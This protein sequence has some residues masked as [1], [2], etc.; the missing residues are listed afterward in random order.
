MCCV[1]KPCS[2]HTLIFKSITM[3]TQSLST[4]Q[5]IHLIEVGE[6]VKFTQ[7]YKIVFKKVSRVYQLLYLLSLFETSMLPEL[8]LPGHSSGQRCEVQPRSNC[9]TLCQGQ[10][11]FVLLKQNQKGAKEEGFLLRRCWT[12]PKN[13]NQLYGDWFTRSVECQWSQCTNVLRTDISE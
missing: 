4:F 3:W 2:H 7:R 9:N 5:F 13:N 1:H 11:F 6:I 10:L 8:N 12:F